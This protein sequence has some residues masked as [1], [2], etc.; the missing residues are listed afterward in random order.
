M[1]T[2]GSGSAWMHYKLQWYAITCTNTPQPSMAIED[3]LTETEV[4][5]LFSLADI[6]K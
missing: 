5:E 3:T 1:P 4:D 6:S 2:T